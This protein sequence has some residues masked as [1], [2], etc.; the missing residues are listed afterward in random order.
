VSP[1][2]GP[3]ATVRG[4]ARGHNTER[5]IKDNVNPIKQLST[6]PEYAISIKKYLRKRHSIYSSSTNIGSYGNTLLV[7]TNG[8]YVSSI[9]LNKIQSMQI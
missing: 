4:A 9:F 2:Y 1:N 5:T 6:S 3:K 8:F 7:E